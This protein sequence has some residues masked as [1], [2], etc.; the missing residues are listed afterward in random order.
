[1]NV[2]NGTNKFAGYYQAFS[3]GKAAVKIKRANDNTEATIDEGFMVNSYTISAARGVGLMRFMNTDGAVAQ[4]GLLQGG[5][6]LQG[7]VGTVEGFKKLLGGTSDNESDVCNQLVITISA[8]GGYTKCD[9][10]GKETKV[11]ADAQFVLSGGIVTNVSLGGQLDTQGILT[12]TGSVTIQFTQFE[13][14]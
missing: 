9:E 1:M 14:K 8:A 4:L 3:G 12:Q 6:T 10:T 2:F 5:L 13:I 7:L 11:N